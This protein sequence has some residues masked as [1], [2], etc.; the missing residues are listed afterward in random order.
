MARIS[1]IW[2]GAWQVLVSTAIAASSGRR[3]LSLLDEADH[4]DV[5][6]TLFEDA[7]CSVVSSRR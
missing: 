2:R 3:L 7:F 5:I 4:Y 1:E 6:L